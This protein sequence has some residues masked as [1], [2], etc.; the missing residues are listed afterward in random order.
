MDSLSI[1]NAPIM[2]KKSNTLLQSLIDEEVFVLSEDI[3]YESEKNSENF[4]YQIESNIWR[5]YVERDF[6]FD[7]SNV[8]GIL[9]T[10]IEMNNLNTSVTS[11]YKSKCDFRRN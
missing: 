2:K 4:Q 7:K 11:E 5:S 6:G 3:S 9:E 10:L 8:T 1:I